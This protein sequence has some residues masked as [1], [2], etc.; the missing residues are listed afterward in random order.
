MTREDLA[1]ARHE[2]REVFG[3]DGGV[4]HEGE[5]LGVAVRAEQE[6]EA[7]LAQL[8]DRLLLRGVDRHMGRVAE[9]LVL[10]PCLERVDARAHRRLVVAGVLDDQ[11]GG[12]IALHEAHALALLDVV[13]RE[14]EDHLV[15]QLDR[16][17]AR[18][19]DRLRALQRF[20]DVVEVDDVER[21]ALGP[22]HDAH[23]RFDDRD[24]RALG[25]RDQ[26]R[27]AERPRRCVATARE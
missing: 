4:L 20:L 10:A 2:L 17:G 21:R 1:E 16:V 6:P 9:T 24:E 27:H 18:L 11:D 12:G 23:L 15:R 3:I 25:A 13:A 5:R 19:Q 26:P 7:G 8:P 22:I 14:I